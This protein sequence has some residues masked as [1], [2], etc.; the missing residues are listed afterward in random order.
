MHSSLASGQLGIDIAADVEQEHLYHVRVGAAP[1]GHELHLAVMSGIK[2]PFLG[3]VSAARARSRTATSCLPVSHVASLC[4]GAKLPADVGPLVQQAPGDLH[5]VPCR[6]HWE[7]RPAAPPGSSPFCCAR[8]RTSSPPGHHV[9]PPPR[10]ALA[11]CF[12]MPLLLDTSCVPRVDPLGLEHGGVG[13]LVI[14]YCP[15]T[16]VYSRRA[17]TTGPS[18]DL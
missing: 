9:R 6:S 12:S 7:G 8:R 10:R 18:S 17:W 4:Y 16:G 15:K 3:L 5:M 14:D 13:D 2:R 11:C 1:C